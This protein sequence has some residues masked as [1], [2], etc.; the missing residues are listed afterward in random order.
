MASSPLQPGSSK[1]KRQTG[2]RPTALW[3]VLGAL[4]VLAIGQ[5]FF[6]TPGGK[7]IPYSEFKSLVRS[8]Q[9]AEVAVG[10]THIRGVLKKNDDEGTGQLLHH[11]HRRSQAGRRP[12][13][14]GREVQRRAGQPL[15]A[16]DSRLGRADPP[17]DRPVDVL[18]PPHRRRRGRRH[19]VRP[20]QGQDLLRRRRQG[21]LPGRRG[22]G[23]GGAGA[24]RDRRVPEDAE[25]VH[26]PRRQDSQGRA[27]GGPAGHRQDAAGPRRRRRGEGAVLQPAR[28]RSSSRCS[29]AWAPPGC[30]IC[31][32]RPK[33]RRPASSSSTSWTRWARCACRARWAATKSAS[34]RSTS[35]SPRWTASMPRKAIIIMA[36][37]NR[38]EVLDPAL[39]RPGRFDRQVLVDKP[40]IN[41]REAVLRIHVRQREAG[42]GSGP[43]QGCGAHGRVCRRRPREPRQRGGAA[44]GATRQAVGGRWRTS[45]KPSTA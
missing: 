20:Q 1:D 33:P 25:E 8:G 42:A 27:A 11:A 39:M 44:G 23:R 7:Q 17:A 2:P 29:S 15:A 34:R 5:A 41:G 31:S 9:V 40:D 38:P 26:D 12:R 14:V 18:L 3:W 36:A 37:T 35:C 19:V 21:Q 43:D 22:R 13:A 32:P 4:L 28:A 10:D 30:A 24:A 45:T 6:L 16:R